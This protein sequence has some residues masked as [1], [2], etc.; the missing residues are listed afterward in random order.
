M[1]TLG[2]LAD[3]HIPDRLPQLNPSVL[4]IFQR[5][6]VNAILHAGDVSIP[7]VLEELR[8]VAPVHA[9]QGNRDIFNLRHLPMRIELIF[10]GVSLGMAHGHGTFSRYMVDKIQRAIQGRLVGSY[11]TR[12]Q[13]TFPHVDVIVFGHLHVPCNFLLDGKLFFN[14]GSTSYPWPRSDPG[15]LGLLYLEQG[16]EPKGEIIILD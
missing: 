4:E 8:R 1:I 6:K 2:V 13:Q 5:A 16:R 9:V 7:R 12:M 14:P 10:E 11:L 3:T 15:S